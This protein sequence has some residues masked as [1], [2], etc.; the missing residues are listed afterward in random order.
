MRFHYCPDCG[1]RLELR[2]IGDEGMVPYCAACSRPWFD[3][4]SACSITLVVNEDNE[5]L[6]LRQNY[7]STQNCTLVSGYIKPGETAEETARREVL[8][9]TG[10]EL[11]DLELVGTYWFSVKGLLMIG[12]FGRAKK[13]ALTPSVEVDA[14]QWVPVED[15]I[16]M[17]S[18]APYSTAHKLVELYLQRMGTDA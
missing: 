14:A 5:A 9:E 13:A 10:V 16:H 8:E 2:S 1:T 11:D 4:F 3:M 6:L 17:V 12:F 7:I 18:Q 15:A